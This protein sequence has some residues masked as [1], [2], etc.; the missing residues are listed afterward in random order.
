MSNITNIAEVPEI[1]WGDGYEGRTQDLL[2][3]EHREQAYKNHLLINSNKYM[4]LVPVCKWF[5]LTHG[6]HKYIVCS[7]DEKYPDVAWVIIDLGD[8]YL[9][10]DSVRISEISEFTHPKYKFHD[11]E[12][13]IIWE[14]EK[15][16]GEYLRDR[17]IV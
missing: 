5:S 1:D 16:I 9:E 10:Y 12:R 17:Q 14:P 6:Q 13:D 2:L 4:A 3:P 15:T 11:F 8:G 7:I